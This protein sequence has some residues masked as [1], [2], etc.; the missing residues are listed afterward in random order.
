M[1]REV[2]E[3]SWC[4]G[5]GAPGVGSRFFWKD[6]KTW[7]LAPLGLPLPLQAAQTL[8]AQHPSMSLGQS[9]SRLEGWRWLL[10]PPRALC[11]EGN[12][13]SKAP[14]RENSRLLPRET[15]LP[16]EFCAAFCPP[17]SSGAAAGVLQTAGAW[18]GAAVCVHQPRGCALLRVMRAAACLHLTRGRLP[19]GS[20][21]SRPS[22]PGWP[23]PASQPPALMPFLPPVLPDVDECSMNNGS[24][25]QGCVNTKGSYE[26][27]CPPGRR[28]HWNRK[29]C[30]GEC[31]GVGRRRDPLRRA[32]CWP[33]RSHQVPGWEGQ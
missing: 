24:C 20:G 33:P 15:C 2:M 3:H 31:R 7:A 26:C 5:E 32:G 28:L 16:L 18:G 21:E 6:P 9:V 4:S 14:A 30:V 8:R 10:S 22:C 25:D 13:L 1:R 19:A 12:G 11:T 27:V 17:P 29:D 23:C